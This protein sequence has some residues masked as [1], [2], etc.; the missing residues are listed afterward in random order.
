MAGLILPR[1][2]INLVYCPK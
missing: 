1:Y 2:Y